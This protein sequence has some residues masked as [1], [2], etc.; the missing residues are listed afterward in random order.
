MEQQKLLS[1]CLREHQSLASERAQLTLQQRERAETEKKETQRRQA[2]S[3]THTNL[4]LPLFNEDICQM[5]A[6][7]EAALATAK[8]ENTR[9]STEAARLEVEESRLKTESSCVKQE[10]EA[11]QRDRSSVQEQRKQVEWREE[12]ANKL[13]QVKK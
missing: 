9:L 10:K 5:E 6:E 12:E 7:L 2:V 1:E 13:R 4:S 11:V 3:T 8:E